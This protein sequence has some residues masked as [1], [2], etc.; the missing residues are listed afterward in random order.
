MSKSKVLAGILGGIAAGVAIGM[1]ISPA[2]GEENRKTV[3]QKGKKYY[4]GLQDELKE[5]KKKWYEAKGKMEESASLAAEEVD[6]LVDYIVGR[7]KKWWAKV[8][9]ASDDL[10]NEV[11]KTTNQASDIAQSTF[12][13]FVDETKDVIND[14][15][16]KMS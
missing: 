3:K 5:S 7:G 4:D 13:N 10:T 2:S 11:E 6:E 16:S 1:L 9:N 14:V 15:K 12:K 8:K